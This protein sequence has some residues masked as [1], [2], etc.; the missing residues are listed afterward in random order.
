MSNDTKQL[1]AALAALDPANIAATSTYDPSAVPDVLP[2]RVTAV[3]GSSVAAFPLR[4]SHTSSYIGMPVHGRDRRTALVGDAAHTIHPLAGQGLNMGL[5]D[6]E[7][8]VGVLEET[9]QKG[10]DVGE[11][12]DTTTETHEFQ[13]DLPSLFAT[14]A[15][16]ALR[17]YPRSRY[18]PNH[19][20]LSTCDHLFSL[21]RSQNPL[22]TWARSTG[23]ET[24]NELTPLKKL[25]MAG[26]G[27]NASTV[28]GGDRG[29]ANRSRGVGA[30]GVVADG[31]ETVRGGIKVASA[32]GGFVLGQVKQRVG[33]V[34][35]V[36]ATSASNG[37]SAEAFSSTR[38]R[39]DDDVVV[40][41]TP[42]SVVRPSPT[43]APPSVHH[44]PP[45]TSAAPPPPPPASAP[46]TDTPTNR[47]I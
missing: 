10:G 11:W 40:M 28:R 14:G 36:A 25:F 6:V 3:D 4:L 7:A 13:S 16:T 26:A 15:Y 38:R 24:I 43:A 12:R 2:P 18:I 19:A 20:L 47:S 8:L 44:P 46:L 39:M 32:L 34:A 33:S 42:S 35:A 22:I 37:S 29:R 31:I 17:A 9:A 27:A 21:Y 23:L 5:G 30:W 1:E 41:S 45:S